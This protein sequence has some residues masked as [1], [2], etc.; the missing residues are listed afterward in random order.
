[1]Y[2]IDEMKSIGLTDE[3]IMAIQNQIANENK[4]NVVDMQSYKKDDDLLSESNITTIEQIKEYSRGS[5]VRLPDFADGQPFIARVK[6]PSLLVLV[7]TGKIPNSLLN[8]ATDLFKSGAS[9]LGEGNTVSDL[10]SI[11]ETIC[12][13]ALVE[14][15]YRD[16]KNAGLNLND[17]QMMAIFSYTQ[18]GVKA[19]ESFRQ[20]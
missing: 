4:E 2:S 17:E 9:S 8:Q 5:I 3:Q 6:R 10:Y 12:E 18:Q 20:R 1:M 13:S 16:I 14:P 11:M 19:L 7:K 15:S